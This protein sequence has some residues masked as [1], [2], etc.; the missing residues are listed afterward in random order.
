LAVLKAGGVFVPLDTG[1]PEARMRAVT[2]DAGA[3]LLLAHEPTSGLELGVATLTVEAGTDTAVELPDSVPPDCAAYVMYTSGSTGEPK[4]V[5]ATHRD[6]VRLALDRCW[7]TAAR[8]LFH[9]PHAFDASSY[10][11]WVPLLSG[12]TVV[13][14]PD[15]RVDAASIRRSISA[16]GLTHIHVTAGLLRALADDDPGCFAGVREV[17]TGGDVVTA[18]AVRQVLEAGSGVVVRHLYGPT[19]VTL[20]ATQHEIA[21]AAE[22]GVALPIGRPLDNTRVYVLDDGLNVVPVG[23]AGEL[24]VAG[25]GIARGY[26]NRAQSTAERFVACPYGTGGRMYRTGDLARWTPDGRLVFAGRADDQVKIRGFRVEPGEVEA[27]LAGHPAVARATVVVREDVPGDKRLVGYVVPVDGSGSIA[28]A[29]RDHVAGRLPEYLVPAS[30][31]ELAALP[32]TVNGK[33][34]RAALPAPEYAAG[35]GRT[36]ANATEE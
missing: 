23:V 6:V 14:A 12:G 3:C 31:V 25:A 19:E 22:A 30:F 15:E 16:H 35:A 28:D 24:Y 1:W 34:D 20:C 27:V 26:V 9:A 33:V 10:E 32:L 8:V 5:V 36:P 18:D 2:A 7:G 29:V 4:G 21:E 17:L 11:L 13:I